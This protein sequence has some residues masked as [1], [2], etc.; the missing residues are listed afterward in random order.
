MH[1]IAIPLVKIMLPLV[2][3]YIA[4]PLEVEIQHLLVVPFI[5]TLQDEIML[6]LVIKLYLTIQLVATMLQLELTPYLTI[7]QDQEVR[8]LDIKLLITIQ[9]VSNM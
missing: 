4:I 5:T 2:K 7:P 8:L 6:R 3:R 9:Q 1:C